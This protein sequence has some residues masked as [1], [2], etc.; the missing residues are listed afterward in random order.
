MNEKEKNKKLASLYWR[1]GKEYQELALLHDP[2]IATPAP[3]ALVDAVKDV[4]ALLTINIE[5][6]NIVNA[7]GDIEIPKKRLEFMNNK[8]QSALKTAHE[9][10]VG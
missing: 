6:S 3:D 4:V 2:F 7:A 1:V 9:K 5:E 8:L 10:A